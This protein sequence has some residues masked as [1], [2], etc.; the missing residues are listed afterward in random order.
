MM[1][2]IDN[3]TVRVVV[4]IIILILSTVFGFLGGCTYT[5]NKTNKSN[6]IRDINSSKVDSIS[7]KNR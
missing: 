3:Q 6:E 1:E 4:E 7:Q 5:K 2:F